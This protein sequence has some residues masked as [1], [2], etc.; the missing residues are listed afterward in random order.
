MMKLNK[1][2]FPFDL[3]LIR[4]FIYFSIVLVSRNIKKGAETITILFCERLW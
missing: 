1:V 2:I 3:S 4:V